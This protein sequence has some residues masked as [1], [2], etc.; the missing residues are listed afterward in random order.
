MTTFLKVTALGSGPY[1]PLLRLL[2]V[3]ASHPSLVALPERLP[4]LADGLTLLDG[5]KGQPRHRHWVRHE[6][7]A[8]SSGLD[9]WEPLP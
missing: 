1:A 4:L 2:A 3:A 5:A 6:R 7:W 9:A 8:T